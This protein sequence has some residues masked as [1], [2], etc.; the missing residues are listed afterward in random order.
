MQILATHRALFGRGHG[1]SVGA[2]SLSEA[3]IIRVVDVLQDNQAGGGWALIGAHPLSLVTEPR[4]TNDFDFVIDD[5][6]LSGILHDLASMFGDLDPFV[7]DVGMRLKALEVD[8]IRASNH[9]LLHSA[10]DRQN[11]VDG[12]RVPRTEVL[13]ALRFLSSKSAWRP[14]HKRMQDMADI[15]TIWESCGHELDRAMLLELGGLVFPGADR[16]LD[17][18]LDQLARGEPISI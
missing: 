7:S 12:W 15:A 1:A 10:L 18:V 11:I 14:R 13:L 2:R 9:A 16:E 17:Q 6:R 4:A 8:L 5:D 3:D